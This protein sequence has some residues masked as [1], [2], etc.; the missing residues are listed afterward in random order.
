VAGRD[1]GLEQQAF[2]ILEHPH[3]ADIP[4]WSAV[5]EVE[6][7]VAAQLRTAGEGRLRDG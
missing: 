7:A 5:E 1:A 4:G 2:R 3:P 6:A